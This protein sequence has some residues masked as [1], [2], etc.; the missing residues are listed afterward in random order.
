MSQC[1]NLLCKSF[2]FSGVFSRKKYISKILRKIK[3][4][5]N[6][7]ITGD[8]THNP[9]IVNSNNKVLFIR[10]LWLSFFRMLY[11]KIYFDI[12]LCFRLNKI[13]LV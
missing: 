11:I 1:R 6:L 10:L 9:K 8:H 4:S 5:G 2:E 3:A 12:K 7:V 13:L